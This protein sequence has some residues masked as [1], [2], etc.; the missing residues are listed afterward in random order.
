MGNYPSHQRARGGCKVSW[1][2]Y[3]DKADAERAATIA[4][5]EAKR[6]WQMGYDFGYQSPGNITTTEDGMFEVC[7]P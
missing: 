2:I 4:R 7:I 6:K 3:A 1:L 5:R